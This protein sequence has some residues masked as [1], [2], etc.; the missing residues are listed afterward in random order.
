MPRTTKELYRPKVAQ[1]VLRW[2]VYLRKRSTVVEGRDMASK[3][4]PDI[5]TQL[6]N[7]T[8]LRVPI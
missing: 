6:L 2:L 7:D 1:T 4:L 8:P 3:A 5:R